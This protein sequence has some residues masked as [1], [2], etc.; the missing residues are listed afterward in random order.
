M[1]KSIVVLGMVT[2]LSSVFTETVSAAWTHGYSGQSAYTRTGSCAYGDRA[3]GEYVQKLHDGMVGNNLASAGTVYRDNLAWDLDL[4]SSFAD[5]KQFFAFGGHG[6]AAGAFSN[7]KGAGSHFYTANSSTT[8]HTSET[9]ES[10]NAQWDEIRWGDDSMRWATMYQCNFLRNFGNTAYE[11]KIWNMFQGLHLMMGFS[12]IMYL[13][14][15]EG[16]RY[17]A[18]MGAGWT[19][20]DSFF[21]AAAYYQPQL[22][23]G[24][25]DPTGSVIAR[26]KGYSTKGSDNYASSTAAAPVYSSTSASSFSTWD[27]TIAL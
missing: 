19:I 11:T 17:A 18:R 4:T 7:G 1:K 10:S 27:K 2:I 3:G 20:K 24:D 16:G 6:L 9:Q 26:V 22:P 25:S 8:F 5:S 23:Y 12:S 21:D 14:S 15:A 13:D